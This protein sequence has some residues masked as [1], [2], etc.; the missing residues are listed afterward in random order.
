[1]LLGLYVLTSYMTVENYIKLT[2]LATIRNIYAMFCSSPFNCS[3][4]FFLYEYTWC[5]K[6]T[7]GPQREPSWSLTL[8]RTL[9]EINEVLSQ[10]NWQSFWMT[11]WQLR[12]NTWSII[13]GNIYV[14]FSIFSVVPTKR[15]F[16]CT[17]Q[18]VLGK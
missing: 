14:F 3:Q 8:V 7:L 1:M 13:L 4:E 9:S 18:S 17:F 6:V 10:L 16:I 12:H 15:F 2:S 5:L 11:D